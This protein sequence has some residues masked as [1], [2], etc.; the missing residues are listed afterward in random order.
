MLDDKEC[1]NSS[2]PVKKVREG[3]LALWWLGRVKLQEEL[4]KVTW[5]MTA[6]DKRGKNLAQGQWNVV[7]I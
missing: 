7:R 4:L 6:F 5:I 3:V 2:E 1:S